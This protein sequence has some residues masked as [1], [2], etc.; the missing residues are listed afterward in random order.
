VYEGDT[1]HSELHV[2][3]ADPLPEGRGGVLK[4]RS[5]VWAVPGGSEATGETYAGEPDRQV[6]D[7]RFTALQF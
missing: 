2:E 1:L 3:G 6:L 7:W 5:R 4:L